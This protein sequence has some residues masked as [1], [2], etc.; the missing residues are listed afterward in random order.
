[1]VITSFPG[2][3][4][5]FLFMGLLKEYSIHVPKPYPHSKEELQR[6]SKE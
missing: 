5:L 1:L 3:V 6:R 4:M 2:T